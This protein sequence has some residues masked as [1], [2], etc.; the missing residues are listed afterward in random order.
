MSRMK[1]IMG[2]T[3][4]FIAASF[5]VLTPLLSC[6]SDPTMDLKSDNPVIW[7]EAAETLSKSKDPRV[8]TPLIDALKNENRHIR[9]TAAE[10][11]GE[12]GDPKAVEPLI[13]VLNDEYWEVRKKAVISLGII[14]DPQAIDSLIL[15]LNDEDGDVRFAASRAL[16]K[17]GDPAINSL[18]SA[19][20]DSDTVTRKGAA[21]TLTKIGWIPSTTGEKTIFLLANQKWDELRA[22]GAPAAALLVTSLGDENS[23]VRKRAAEL[24][25][26]IGKPA[27]GAL[28]LALE[29]R[30]GAVRKKAAEIL[31]KTGWHPSN[32]EEKAKI[33]L[34]H[35][36]WK[37]LRE[38]GEP[39]VK[40]LVRALR[41]KE[42][43][44]RKNIAETLTKTGWRPQEREEKIDFLLALQNWNELVKI[45]APAIKS[46]TFALQDNNESIRRKAAEA[47]GKTAHPDAVEPL[48]SAL[49][50]EDPA[51]RLEAAK[52]L[53]KIGN[54]DAVK[55]LIAALEDENPEVSDE[56]VE[57]LAE[58]G[59]P[60]VNPLMN[61]LKRKKRQLRKKAAE[62]LGKIGDAAAVD[63]L[64]IALKDDDWRVAKASSVA[65]GKIGDK[66]A[67][68]PLIE[69]L[70]DKDSNVR[71]GSAEALGKIGNKRSVDPLI[72]ALEDDIKYVR[73]KAAESLGNIGDRSAAEYLNKALQD[74]DSDVRKKAAGALLK[75]GWKPPDIESRVIY[76]ISNEKWD[77]LITTG[78]LA[79]EPLIDA[80]EDE[81]EATR[82]NAAATLGKIGDPDA[83]TPLI[84][85]LNDDDSSVRTE[86]SRALQKIG[87][88]AVYP[89]MA[90]LKDNDEEVRRKAAE[91][92]GKIGDKKAVSP[93]VRYLNEGG[94]NAEVIEALSRLD[95]N[96]V[97]DKE[98]VRWWVAKSDFKSLIKNWDITKK[99]LLRDLESLEYVTVYNALSAFI[100]TGKEEIIPEIIL[101]LNTK[102][103][104]IM[105]EAYLNC[106]HPKLTEAAK[107]WAE[108]HGYSIK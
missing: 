14:R 42:S 72:A 58:I 33:L 101:K 5:F 36:K 12:M 63:L 10:A 53:R 92:L 13:S 8:L 24:L 17:I 102:G 9:K 43:G 60:A 108:K 21:E 94:A 18:V 68:S 56:A 32:Q 50:D 77:D 48:A 37:E 64:I 38:M 98:K 66:R 86:A 46:L 7:A 61:G 27:T 100:T 71:E 23:D 83:V 105:A 15:S 82:R 4:F 70:E 76:L 45:G 67:V 75:M 69:A 87:A 34:A 49:K 80:L 91:T 39:A 93:L 96:P 79:V 73:G 81:D 19:L 95:W 97:S 22:L 31:I 30:D 104:E 74:R 25:G 11:L 88:P 65:L 52:S 2:R 78:K 40:P 29:G 103:N 85:K 35:E 55:Y 47:L 59:T 16:E 89:L 107:D 57:A 6:Q 106:G 99:I 54:A 62:A 26:K 28:V 51:T 3:V 20:Q 41:D 1:E 84:E 44:T 90:A